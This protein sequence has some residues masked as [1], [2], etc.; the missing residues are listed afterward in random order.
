MNIGQ[1]GKVFSHE[2]SRYDHGHCQLCDT[3]DSD[4]FD[5]PC[6]PRCCEYHSKKKCSL[7]S[8]RIRHLN[9]EIDKSEN[10]KTP[11]LDACI[12]KNCSRAVQAV[13]E[14]DLRF[15]KCFL[16]NC[17]S[18]ID[19]SLPY[20]PKYTYD[21]TG[22]NFTLLQIAIMEDNPEAVELILKFQ[23]DTNK[24][25]YP[26]LL[27]SHRLYN[28]TFDFFSD[29]RYCRSEKIHDMIRLLLAHGANPNI[30]YYDRSGLDEPRTPLTYCIL[31]KSN[32]AVKML[33]DYGA[34]PLPDV[35]AD[36]SF[37]HASMASLKKMFSSPGSKVEKKDVSYDL[38]MIE[39]QLQE[40]EVI[41][42]TKKIFSA[43][44]SVDEYY[45]NLYLK[46]MIEHG[47]DINAYY[48]DLK[49]IHFACTPPSSNKGVKV[50]LEHGADINAPNKN[51]EFTALHQ[52]MLSKS[53][54]ISPDFVKE[55][56][57][58]GADFY[59]EGRIPVKNSNIMPPRISHIFKERHPLIFE[60]GQSYTALELLPSEFPRDI[61]FCEPRQ[62]KKIAKPLNAPHT[63]AEMAPGA[64]KKQ[65]L[66]APGATSSGHPSYGLPSQLP[67][68]APSCP[69]YD[70]DVDSHPPSCK[71]EMDHSRDIDS[72]PPPFNP[73]MDH[74]RDVDDPPPSYE[75][76]FPNNEKPK[77]KS[78]LPWRRK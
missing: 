11:E 52:L 62:K 29:S 28:T 49:L 18:H 40:Q 47:L 13:V 15:L 73:C 64:D 74:S 43:Y 30:L 9:P 38:R 72:R 37:A 19:A 46:M 7:Y 23:P 22:K 75:L 25:P 6:I 42:I 17:P 55:L 60:K 51:G 77:K 24:K 12:L 57:S 45:V 31:A 36:D 50:L 33:L 70:S 41:Q 4:D 48:G 21:H 27:A 2:F 26:L 68:P 61:F 39:G 44:M 8:R 3:D 67:Y 59:I 66:P 1:G 65:P 16:T 5:E 54:C 58:F 78:W 63:T 10:E 32:S 35:R 14:N 56:L 53:E 71:P 34:K 20:D 69:G 76:L